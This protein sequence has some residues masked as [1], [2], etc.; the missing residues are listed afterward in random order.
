[1]LQQLRKY[2]DEKPLLL[3]LGAGLFLR[4][5]AVVFSK[6]FGFFDDHFLIIEAGQSWADGTDYNN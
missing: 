6:G 2:W 4:L 3:I 5:L 1:M